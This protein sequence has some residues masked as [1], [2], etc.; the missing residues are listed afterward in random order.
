MRRE[1]LTKVGACSLGLLPGTEALANWGEGEYRIQ[2]ALYGT[3]QR[4][5]DVTQ[6]LRDLAKRDARFQLSNRTFGVDPHPGKVKT[7]RIIA[8]SGSGRMRTFEYTEGSWV[9]GGEFSGWSGGNWGQGGFGGSPGYHDGGEGEYRILRAHY[10]TAENHIDVTQAL[11]DLARRDQR[12][13]LSNA[14]FGSDPDRGRVKSLRIYAKGPGG[15][16]RIFEYVEGGWVDGAQ[17]SGWSGGQ[18]GHASDGTWD[19]GWGGDRPGFGNHSSGSGYDSG[20]RIITAEYGA[21]NRRINI[22]RR[23]QDRVLNGRLFIKV[24]NDLAGEDPAVNRPKQ[25]WVV[26]SANGREQRRVLNEGQFLNLP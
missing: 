9:D 26:Y 7:L 18:W 20:V 24:N 4:N 22:T 10:G 12:F 1:F 5:V 16:P 2:Q 23:L 25:L 17:F 13:K 19:G 11:R 6:R 8:T 3:N 21:G 15:T 14:T